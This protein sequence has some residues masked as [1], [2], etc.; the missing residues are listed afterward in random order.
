MDAQCHRHPQQDDKYQLVHQGLH[1]YCAQK[2]DLLEL[3]D[4][5]DPQVL[6]PDW[7]DR[8]G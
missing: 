6:I 7:H 4:F 1:H 5:P 2:T 8:A 3:I